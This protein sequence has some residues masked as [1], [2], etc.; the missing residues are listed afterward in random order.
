[1]E[2]HSDPINELV[3]MLRTM[4]QP[5]LAWAVR[6]ERDGEP[7]LMAWRASRDPESMCDLIDYAEMDATRVVAE[8]AALTVDLSFSG[9]FDPYSLDADVTRRIT[10]HARSV[11]RMP[12]MSDLF[13]EEKANLRLALEIERTP[14]E[15]FGLPDKLAQVRRSPRP[16]RMAMERLVRLDEHVLRYAMQRARCDAIRRAVPEPPPLF[17]LVRPRERSEFRL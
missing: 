13:S 1:M 14:E 4:G 12:P 3:D 6:W 8:L 10:T 17:A 15:Q 5:T 2:E 16:A 9:R 11:P 7:V